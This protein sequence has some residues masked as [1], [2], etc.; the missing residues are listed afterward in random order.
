MIIH[1]HI[2]SVWRTKVSTKGQLACFVCGQACVSAGHRSLS[3]LA[4]AQSIALLALDGA[5]A[6][7]ALVLLWLS[8]CAQPTVSYAIGASMPLQGMGVS[9]I[10]ALAHSMASSAL[11]WKV[12]TFLA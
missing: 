3:W 5:M 11:P 2:K 7:L 9:A 12:S 8:R 4:F 6:I 10:L 1:N